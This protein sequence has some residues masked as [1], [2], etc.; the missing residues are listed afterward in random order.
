V[1]CVQ[2]DPVNDG[3]PESET[4][5]HALI[6]R[7]QRGRARITRGRVRVVN[8]STTSRDCAKCLRSSSA[9]LERPG[10]EFVQS[11]MEPSIPASEL[12]LFSSAAA[13]FWLERGVGG[14]MRPLGS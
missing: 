10:A 3:V 12:H 13:V 1:L 11:K 2:G 4:S 7:G 9:K 14:S 8:P 5:R 6:R